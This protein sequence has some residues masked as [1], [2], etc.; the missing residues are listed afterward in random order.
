MAVNLSMLAGAGAQFFDNNGIPLAGGLVYTYAAGTTTPQATYTTSAG[1]IAHANPIVLDSAGRIP[2]GGE[3]WLTDAV[4][5]KFVLKTSGA[6]TIGTYDNVIGN[7]SG[8][9]AAFAASSGSSLVGYTQTGTGA[10][11]TTVQARLRQYVS[12]IDFG[13]D[14]TG[15]SDSTTAFTNAQGS[16]SVQ[17]YIPAGTYK[18]NGLRILNGV[19]LIGAGKSVVTINQAVAGTA[20]INCTSDVTVGQLKNVELSGFTVVGATS[21]TVAAILVAAYGAYAI[22]NSTFDYSAKN[23]YRAL[24]IQGATA[25]NVFDSKFTVQSEGTSS[26]AVLAN[27]GVYN[28][29]DLFLTQCASYS[30]VETGAF[31]CTFVKLVSDNCWTSSGQ[32]TVFINPTVEEIYSASAPTSIVI[33]LTGFNQT[34]I[35]PTVILNAGNS[36][37][38]TYVAVPATQTSIQQPRFLCVVTNPFFEFNGIWTLLGPGQSN[39]TNKIETIYDGSGVTKNLRNVTFV[40]N[41]SSFTLQSVPHGGKNVQYLAPTTSFNFTAL[42]NTDAVIFD[43]TGTIATANVNLG[44]TGLPLVNNQVM[45]FYSG[46]II[47]AL[48]LACPAGADVTLLPTTMAAGSKFN[49]VYYSTNNKWYPI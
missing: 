34:L 27:G 10:V 25:N 29:F 8:I 48:T 39:C 3:I 31:N 33:S 14:P 32:N 13:A 26:T 7:A 44:R 30:L 15:V 4:A 41:C 43:F 6:S 24:E 40:G 49:A 37:K 46:G 16:G 23:T 2:S 19:R 28:L 35:G 22:W 38:V 42:N 21:A 12:V 18:L 17:V 45:S 1:S 36:A 5:Y 20:A 47:T 9:Y 11:A